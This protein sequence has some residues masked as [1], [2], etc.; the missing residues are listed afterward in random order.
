MILSRRKAHFY[1][2]ICLSC[3][4]CV[5]FLAGLLWRPATPLVD[6]STDELF[7]A[8]NFA[9][10]GDA[11][12]TLASE[13]LSINGVNLEV[14]TAELP[15]GD[16]ALLVQPAQALQFSDVLVYWI[17]GDAVLENI[18]DEAILLGQL[19]GMSLRSFPILPEMR[20]QS[21]SLLLYSRSQE[22][23][24]AAVPLPPSL[25]PSP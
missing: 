5:V 19:S 1:A 15:N 22:T 23:A 14:R 24:I 11:I 20:S 8:A 13:T 25:F 6:E 18:D 9:K 7:A 2:A 3:T 10:R 17:S 12:G 21:G 16:L 4:L